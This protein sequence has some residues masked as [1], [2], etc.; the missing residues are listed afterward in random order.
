MPNEIKVETPEEVYTRVYGEVL[1][2]HGYRYTW[3]EDQKCIAVCLCGATT[4]AVADREAAG[5]LA[6]LHGHHE[7]ELEAIKARTRLLEI[8]DHKEKNK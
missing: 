7:A 1:K 8:Q 5:S 4:L 3:N 2:A 6:Y